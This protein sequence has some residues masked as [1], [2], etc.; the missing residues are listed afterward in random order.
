[1]DETLCDL[2]VKLAIW[3]L[4]FGTSD[5]N[6]APAVTYPL[7]ESD[8]YPDEPVQTGDGFPGFPQ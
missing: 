7:A 1:M 6:A 3:N 5:Q 2:Y 4:R 8:T